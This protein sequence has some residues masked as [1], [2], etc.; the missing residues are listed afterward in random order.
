MAAR[1]CESLDTPIVLSSMNLI[2]LLATSWSF[3]RAQL[4]SVQVKTL[5]IETIQYMLSY[6]H[7]PLGIK[8]AL[9]NRYII[10]S[11]VESSYSYS[12]E[13]SNAVVKHFLFHCHFY[14]KCPASWLGVVCYLT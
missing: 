6:D 8:T 2:I 10:K 3:T 12:V 9:N 5:E 7:H 13:P 4:E 11:Q 1:S 14:E